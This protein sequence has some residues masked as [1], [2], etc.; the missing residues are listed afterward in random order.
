LTNFVARG[1]PCL[2]VEPAANVAAVARAAGVPSE[3]VFLGENTAR[4]I[5]AV[6]GPANLL[7][8]NN[9][10][11]HVPAINDFVAGLRTL[12][13]EDGVLTVECPHLARLIAG[14]QFDTIYHE[15]FFY[16]SLT[17]IERI[18]AA[19][20]LRLFDIEELPTHG[21]SLRIFAER[22]DTK[23]VRPASQA[24]LALRA[25]ERELGIGEKRYYDGFTRRV[26][27]TIA[28]V[29]DFLAGARR[30]N[31]TV[32]VYG[33]AAKGNT[34]LNACGVTAADIAYAVDGNPHKQGLYLPGTHVPV[35][36]PERIAE[37]RPDYVLILAWNLRDE[38]VRQ[39]KHVAAWGGKFAVPIPELQVFDA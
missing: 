5:V 23:A 35:C 18:F 3:C 29:R 22:A 14:V 12:L 27:A 32:V 8:A 33:A 2:G 21:G 4:A 37:T 36:A 16:F 39:T 31:K 9:V 17:A 10:L 1:I 13:A 20:G 19:H 34:L 26:A 7:V 6:G 15:H 11:A 28:S 25:S 24:L 30:A 38:I